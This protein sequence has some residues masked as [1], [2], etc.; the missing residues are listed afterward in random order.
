MAI[1]HNVVSASGVK[2]RY[3]PQSLEYRWSFV[4]PASIKLTEYSGFYSITVQRLKSSQEHLT[5][6]P[7]Q[8]PPSPKRGQGKVLIMVN[9]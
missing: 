4:K 1:W 3:N 6:I 7:P 2:L 8:T 9:H 5:F